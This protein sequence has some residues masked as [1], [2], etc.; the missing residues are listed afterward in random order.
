MSQP[1]PSLGLAFCTGGL[2]GQVISITSDQAHIGRSSDNTICLTQ[3]D[4]TVSGRHATLN[5]M[6]GS[7]TIADAGSQTGT[8]VVGKQVRKGEHL[9]IQPGDWILFGAGGS[10]AMVM[11]PGGSAPRTWLVLEPENDPSGFIAVAD[12]SGIEISVDDNNVLKCPALKNAR[13]GYRFCLDRNPVSAVPLDHNDGSSVSIESGDVLKLE[14]DRAGIRVLGVKGTGGSAKMGDTTLRHAIREEIGRR[15]ALPYLIV[16][17]VVLIAIAV[18]MFLLDSRDRQH[19][20]G[21]AR[22]ER[23]RTELQQEIAVLENEFGRTI[24]R[25]QEDFETALRSHQ[26]EF[27]E[28]LKRQEEETQEQLE[29]MTV[30]DR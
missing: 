28:A 14:S 24:D 17:A 22:L 21:Q 9:N 2:A 12:T 8:Y 1:V 19:Q 26:E 11:D 15:Q 5:H 10:A 18:T 6:D 13:R 25:Q 30:S 27:K 7:W 16:V 4:V 23:D 20:R 3:Q 29:A